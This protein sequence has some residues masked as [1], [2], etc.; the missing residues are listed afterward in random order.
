[1][2][3]PW[4]DKSPAPYQGNDDVDGGPV[5]GQTPY[6]MDPGEGEFRTPKVAPFGDDTAKR[7]PGGI[8]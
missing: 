1:M 2:P 7:K 3:K 5:K 8:F 6:E 4:K